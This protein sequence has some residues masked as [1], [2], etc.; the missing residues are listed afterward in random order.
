MNG[1]RLILTWKTIDD[2]C[3][4]LASNI[5]VPITHVVGIARGGLIPATLIA[6]HLNVREVMSLGLKSYSDGDDYETREPVPDVY[7]HIKQCFQLVR[8]SSKILI[9]DDITDKGNT[10]NFI[11]N[12]LR[13]MSRGVNFY[14]AALFYKESSIYTPTYTHTKVMDGEWIVFPWEKSDTSS[15]GLI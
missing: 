11:D 6:K 13:D 10:F 5:N 8:G 15:L 2:A 9:V 7:Q 3:E 14:T 1:N 4:Q 12:Y